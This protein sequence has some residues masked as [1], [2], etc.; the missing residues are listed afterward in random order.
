MSNNRPKLNLGFEV[1]DI[2]WLISSFVIARNTAMLH[3]TPEGKRVEKRIKMILAEMQHFYPVLADHSI[4]NYT[5]F[6]ALQHFFGCK[7][8][9]LAYSNSEHAFMPY[10]YLGVDD[11]IYK[12]ADPRDYKEKLHTDLKKLFTDLAPIDSE[13]FELELDYRG[14]IEGSDGLNKW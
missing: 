8:W 6:V 10:V 5:L 7:R 3:F 13:Y 1:E 11:K 4:E 12:I 2:P 14:R 9:S